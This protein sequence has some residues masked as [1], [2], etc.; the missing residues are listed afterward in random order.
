MGTAIDITG[1]RFGRLV[2]LRKTD[3]RQDKKIIWE[4]LCDCGNTTKALAKSAK[5]GN[6]K[7][8]GCLRNDTPRLL[9]EKNG[10]RK[11]KKCGF[12]DSRFTVKLSHFER[13]H[14]CSKRC[15]HDAQK[16]TF[17]GDTNPHWKGGIS[18]CNDHI[19][20]RAKKWRL[21]NSDK[22]ALY[23]RTNKNKR[24]GAAGSHTNDDVA[25]IY[26]L[27]KG[28]CAYCNK[29]VRDDYHI[30]HVVPVSKGGTNN[31]DNICISCPTCNLKKHAK[32]PH[33]WAKERGMLL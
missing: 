16:V 3:E 31:K 8:C 32:L 19:N 26:D 23:N 17:I 22:I 25:E 1:Q 15:Q 28:R 21:K 33:D 9:S 29:K 18:L 10:L 24:K 30:D 11:I 2:A 12:C 20:E 5:C 7:S 6:T 13:S 14:Y 27:Q 4:F